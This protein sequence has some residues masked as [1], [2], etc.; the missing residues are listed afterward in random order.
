MDETK[1]KSSFGTSGLL[2]SSSAMDLIG[3]VV[4]LLLLFSG[5]IAVVFIIIGGYWYVISGGNEET[6]E[7]GKKT[8]I[9]AIIGIVVIVLSYAIIN[10]I[11][12]QVSRCS[13]F[14]C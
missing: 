13:G 9:N 5:A 6:A 8:L 14:F 1:L 10:V 11:A 3:R 4:K 7:K 12:R 2:G